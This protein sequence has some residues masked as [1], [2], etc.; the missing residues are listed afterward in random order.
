MCAPPLHL[1]RY[2]TR[3]PLGQCA[4]RS[5]KKQNNSDTAQ[6]VIPTKS[7]DSPFSSS[8]H[9][10]GQHQKSFQIRSGYRKR[11]STHCTDLAQTSSNAEYLEDVFLTAPIS[12]RPAKHLVKVKHLLRVVHSEVHDSDCYF[13]CDSTVQYILFCLMFALPSLLLL[14][15]LGCVSRKKCQITTAGQIS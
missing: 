11:C 9:Q 7:S 1:H 8:I 4:V 12:V 6:G 14:L 13:C 10:Y 2:L 5:F 15:V 3:T